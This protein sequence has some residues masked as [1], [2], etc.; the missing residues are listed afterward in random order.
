M[1]D[2]ASSS[3]LSGIAGDPAVQVLRRGRAGRH[4]L[5]GRV[6]GVV[7]GDAVAHRDAGREP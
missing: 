6:E 4:H 3:D 7:I 2:S 1:I 5:E